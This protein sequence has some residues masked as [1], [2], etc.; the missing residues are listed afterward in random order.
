MRCTPVLAHFLP[1]LRNNAV[2]LHFSYRP[3]FA[4]GTMIAQFDLALPQRCPGGIC[5][6]FLAEIEDMLPEGGEEK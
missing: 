4:P 5:E 6:S 2:T 3:Y 1:A